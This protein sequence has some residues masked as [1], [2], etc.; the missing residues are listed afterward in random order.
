MI[1][2]H[3][4]IEYEDKFN[5]KNIQVQILGEGVIQVDEK[6]PG[7]I[8]DSNRT[9]RIEFKDEDRAEELICF[10]SEGM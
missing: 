2:N 6:I 7:I 5:V 1:Y 9:V 8:F 4:K 3:S 10:L